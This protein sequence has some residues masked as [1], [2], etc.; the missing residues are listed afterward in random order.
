[1]ALWIRPHYTFT[2]FKLNSYTFQALASLNFPIINVYGGFGYVSG[3]SNLSLSGRYELEYSNGV[4]SFTKVLNNPLDLD[5]D[6]SG[7]STTI[8]ARLGLGFFKIFG[9]YTLQ[10]YSTAN[11]G[12]AFTIR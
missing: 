6:V 10:E 4:N 3:S 8:G 12:V 9:S 1:L 5:Y 2:E 11:L 7:F